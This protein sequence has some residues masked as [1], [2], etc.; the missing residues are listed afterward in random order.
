MEIPEGPHFASGRLG[1]ERADAS[2]DFNHRLRFYAEGFDLSVE[3]DR[4]AFIL[5]PVNSTFRSCPPDR[6]EITVAPIGFSCGLRRAGLSAR[7]SCRQRP[8]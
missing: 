7:S 5:P 4:V 8:R 1:G 6:Y 3:R 2:C